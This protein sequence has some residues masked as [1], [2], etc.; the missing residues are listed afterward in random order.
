MEKCKTKA[1]KVDLDIF[2]HIQAFVTLEYSEPWNI[3]N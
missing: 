1:I 3:H 2:R